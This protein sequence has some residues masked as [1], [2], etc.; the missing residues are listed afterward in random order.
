[1]EPGGKSAAEGHLSCGIADLGLLFDHGDIAHAHGEGLP[2]RVLR[3]GD[4]RDENGGQGNRGGQVDVAH[5]PGKMA[6]PPA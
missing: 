6:G 2:E 4:G 5:R 3:K 1:M